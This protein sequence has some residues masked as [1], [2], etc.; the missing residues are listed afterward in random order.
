[1]A[2]LLFDMRV[3]ATGLTANR[4]VNQ[5]RYVRRLLEHRDKAPEDLH[6]DVVGPVP[7]DHAEDE[8]FNGAFVGGGEDLGMAEVVLLE[9][10][11]GLER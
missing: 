10:E 5:E 9:A 7:E 8:G 4:I 11:A 1:M 6:G 2:E 3:H